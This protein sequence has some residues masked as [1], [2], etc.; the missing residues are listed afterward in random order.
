MKILAANNEIRCMRYSFSPSSSS[1]FD[2]CQQKHLLFWYQ[3]KKRQERVWKLMQICNFYHEK[4]CGIIID[5]N[6]FG[7]Y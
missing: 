6:L 3:Q 4:C 5:I 7:Y 1:A 2:P